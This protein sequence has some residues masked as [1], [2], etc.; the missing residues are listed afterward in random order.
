[1]LK[2]LVIIH[3]VAA[4]ILIIHIS[5]LIDALWLIPVCLLGIFMGLA[6]SVKPFEFKVKGVMHAVSLTISAFLV[7]LILLFGAVNSNFAWYI[8]L[9][10]I[11]FPVAHY[12]IALANQTGDFLEDKAEGLQSPAVRW[13]L[14]KTLKLAKIMSLLGL[15]LEIIAIWGLVWYAPWLSKIETNISSFIPLRFL[16]ITLIILVITFA[17]SVPIRGLFS[18]HNISKLDL[19]IEKR[20]LKIKDRMN[21][22]IWQASAIWGLVITSIIIGSIS[23]IF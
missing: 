9:L 17:Y 5:I 16:I 18:I 6:Y 15:C 12:G 8:I 4:I 14:N 20:M 1:M 19:G 2:N 22:P 10:S 7:P 21:Y 13:G 11:G 3:V 23:I